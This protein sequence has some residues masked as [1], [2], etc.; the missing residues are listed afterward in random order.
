ME[1]ETCIMNMS[2]GPRAIAR[3]YGT[4]ATSPECVKHLAEMLLKEPCP[5]ALVCLPRSTQEVINK[6]AN[7]SLLTHMLGVIGYDVSSNTR[8]EET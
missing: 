5:S 3:L 2:I 1:D 6:G 7:I 4:Y 8:G